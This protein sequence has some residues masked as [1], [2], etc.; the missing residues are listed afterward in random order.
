[1]TTQTRANGA[2]AAAIVLALTPPTITMSF[3]APALPMIAQHFGG[4]EHAR[5][6]AQHAQSLPFLGLALGG[7]CSGVLIAQ[8][9]LRVTLLGAAVLAVFAAAFGALAQS[10]MAL[11]VACLAIGFSVSVLASALVTTAGVSYDEQSRPRILGFQTAL[12]DLSAVLV[13]VASA[14]LAQAFG[15]RGP[16]LAEIALCTL[17]LALVLRSTIPS[18]QAAREGRMKSM[19]MV[20]RYAGFTYLIA[21]AVF[22][23]LGTQLVL[24]PFLLADHG[25]ATPGARALVL[26]SSPIAAVV[27]ST[28]YALINSR[29]SDRWLMCFATLA[30]TLGY[31]AMGAWHSGDAAILFAAVAAGAGV[32]M[33]FPII[34]RATFRRTPLVLHSYS[35]GMLNTF[36]FSG[37]FLGPFILGPISQSFGISPQFYFCGIVWLTG[38][39]IVFLNMSAIAP[40]ALDPPP[41]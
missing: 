15:W 9:G 28:A 18:L 36:I 8:M 27:A 12:A 10:P 32:G 24:L 34:I 1:M 13:G 3:L 40:T 31:W 21:F 37:A 2:L 7:L 14:L 35:M 23:V 4:D 19:M 25:Y 20:V 29:V 11:H 33:A 17:L 39:A 6:I 26:T 22:F 38:G 16:F 5:S 30:S 41:A